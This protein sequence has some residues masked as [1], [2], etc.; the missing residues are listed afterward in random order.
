MSRRFVVGAIPE[1]AAQMFRDLN[2]EEGDV[3]IASDGFP[4]KL[5][6][7]DAPTVELRRELHPNI[8]WMVGECGK[9]YDLLGTVRD[10]GTVVWADGSER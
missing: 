3:I 5:D 9:T 7:G 6:E 2:V 10:D 1:D 4:E 8:A